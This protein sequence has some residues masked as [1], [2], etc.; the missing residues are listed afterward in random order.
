MR[1]WVKGLALGVATGVGGAALGTLPLGEEFER[2]VA[3][4]WLFGVR[5]E[6]AAPSEVVVVAID[7][8]TGSNLDLPALPRDWSRDVY[9][10][11][12]DRLMAYG[13]SVVIFD[14]ELDKPKSIQGEIAF[15]E[16][17]ARSGRVVLYERL[18]G[19][20]RPI[21]DGSGREVGSMWVEE[22]IPPIPILAE[23]ARGSGPF[24]LPKMQIA[25]DQ[26][27]A[28]KPSAVGAPTLPAVALQIHAIGNYERWHAL[29]REAGMP[30]LEML[31]PH[32]DGLARAAETRN[33][34]RV[35]RDA[36][37]GDD[38]LAER[39]IEAIDRAEGPD[40]GPAE[41]RL[42]RA[43]TGLYAGANSR[44]LNFYGPP[45]TIRTVPFHAVIKGG[46]P[47][48]GADALDLAGKVVF[49]GFSSLTDPGQPDRYFT[50]FTRSD[51]VDLSGVEIAATA[52]GNLLTERSLRPAGPLMSALICVGLGLILGAVVYLV[53]AL[54]GVPLAFAT[55]AAYAAAA[56]FA[57]NSADS[58]LPLAIP[59][60]VQ[61][62]LAL[63][64]GLTGQYL[65]E[66]R[67]E[68]Q[69]S[70]L[71][72]NYVPESVVRS[73]TQHSFDPTALDSVVYG[74]CLATDM[75]GFTSIAEQMKPKELASFVNSYFDRLAESLKRH[76]AN[77]TEFHADTIMCAWTAAQSDLVNRDDAISAALDMVETI[78]RFTEEDPRFQLN[79]RVGLET[80]QFY[81][82]HT[83]GGGHF[84]FSI[85]GDCANTASRLESLNKHI[86][87]K[88]LAT[89]S[90]VE[91]ADGIVMRP[92][93]RFL[94]VGKTN[95]TPV[96]EIVA[97]RTEAS[98]TELRFCARFAEALE[99]F[100]SGRWM[101]AGVRFRAIL[102][103]H[104][105]DGP[106]RFYL[107]R[108]RAY[109]RK[110][111]HQDDPTVIVMD[112]K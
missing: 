64:V 96:V 61:F 34:M 16:A 73:L 82:G 48:L 112:A 108:C 43:L 107:E 24:P 103:D 32:R 76:N 86:G 72:S 20:T 105:Q 14:L 18:S 83:G 52:F 22:L 17:M 75:S 94:F 85:L 84:A 80:G 79:A 87:T 49:V 67:K 81:V 29:L 15:A 13:A 19:Q 45:G 2:K 10:R 5:G 1:Q 50:V 90:V 23:A 89:A 109:Q 44:Y 47:N 66:R 57:F 78:G 3:L 12:V 33:T 41:K 6:I 70:Q 42:L 39:V 46:D 40:I 59:L 71:I 27:W 63:F 99:L 97:R 51:G 36:F 95:P 92:L 93:G 91:E 26:Y 25:V 69:V 55:A 104:P 111:P 88:I 74:T 58:W 8:R 77:I 21:V 110:T 35:L 56:Q 100:D 106:A 9:A 11:L 7:Q 37:S 102:R 4:P 38:D 60:L 54:V 30:G 62:P 53:P 101:R 65:L 68:R 31:P 98:E 28:F